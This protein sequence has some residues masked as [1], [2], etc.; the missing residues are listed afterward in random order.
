MMQ[1]MVMQL[2]GDINGLK[3]Q[4]AQIDLIIPGLLLMT[5]M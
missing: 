1:I 3:Q 4:V 2:S 5:G